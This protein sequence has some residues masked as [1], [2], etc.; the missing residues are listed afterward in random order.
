MVR[1]SNGRSKASGSRRAERTRRAI[2][3]AA[4]AAFREHGY[5]GAGMREIAEKAELSPAN[6]YYYF[7]GKDEILFYCQDHSLDRL[8]AAADEAAVSGEP[9]AAQIGRVIRAHLR[10]VLDE[11]DGASAHLEVDALPAPLR[12]R[13][14]AKRDRY[15]RAVRALVAAGV[16]AG[17]FAGRDP[18]LVTRAILG[19]LNST[20]RWFRPGGAVSAAR[21]ADEY[22]DF[23]VRGLLA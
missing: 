23:L 9:P 1:I 13:V 14:V 6:L 21:L 10:C 5:A 3:Q 7:G 15:E 19:A 8:L 18:I 4:A 2:L 11:L 16:D 12:R 20:V 17:S 22:A